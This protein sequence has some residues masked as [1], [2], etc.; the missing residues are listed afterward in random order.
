MV[1][2]L[3]I[4]ACIDICLKISLG[5][6]ILFISLA[7][8]TTNLVFD[9]RSWDFRVEFEF[10][11]FFSFAFLEVVSGRFYFGFGDVDLEAELRVVVHFGCLGLVLSIDSFQTFK[12]V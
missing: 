2:S 11:L 12:L 6:I 3:F 5:F 10:Y 7:K 9:F 4:L 8:Q 1:L